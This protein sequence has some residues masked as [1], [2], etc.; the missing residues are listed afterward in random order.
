MT[1]NFCGLFQKK[2]TQFPDGMAVKYLD[3]SLSYH[4]LE[5]LSSLFA[6]Q[7]IEM[8]V[9]SGDIIGVGLFNSIHLIV[10]I[11]GILKA[12]GVYLPLD[13][14]YPSI[15]ISQMV[16]DANV[17]LIVIDSQS[18]P[19]FKTL[20]V[21][22][23]LL[24][25]NNLKPTRIKLPAIS[26]KQPAYIIY[27]SGSTGIPKG[28]V[29]SH[30]ALKHAASSFAKVFPFPPRSLLSGSISFDPS[31]LVISH[32]LCTGG[33]VC[34]YDNREG[35]DLK[36]FT[37]ITKIINK[38]NVDFILSTP[39]FYNHILRQREHL[40]SLKNIF[41][42]G[43]KIHTQL[44]H[45][46]IFLA[47]G[48]NLYNTYG[49]SEYAIG[50]TVGLVYNSLTKKQYPVTI[51][52][53]FC[54]NKLYVLDSALNPVPIGAKGEFFVG[55]PGL[56]IGYLNQKSLSDEKFISCNHLGNRLVKLY[57]TGDIGYQIENGNFVFTGR[58]D[59][60]VKIHGH[61]VELEEIESTIM[62][63][64][65]IEKAVAIVKNQNL[66]TFY[67]KNFESLNLK[68]LKKDLKLALPSY[69][70]PQTFVEIQT[71]PIN[72]NGKID[73]KTLIEHWLKNHPNFF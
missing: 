33:T 50:S 62:G 12:G 59:S 16:A 43:E 54:N 20:Q 38:F 48:A 64:T 9:H 46:H 66:I 17:K 40:D 36:D 32:A 63:Y 61:R 5:K 13:P 6:H 51:G 71:W 15:R 30:Y 68:R 25:I 65:G 18:R 55:G 49:P 1:A 26:P 22:K 28:I 39:S 29:V 31:I 41:L 42:C 23:C 47:P 37:Q 53:P 72:C 44:I 8:G 27:T 24:N 7:L 60:Q 11:L 69:M 10:G 34:L 70:I 4:D 57:R 14:N 21:D 67:S 19:H 52:K 73:R 3:D 45:N 58:K 35:I 2:A 56:A